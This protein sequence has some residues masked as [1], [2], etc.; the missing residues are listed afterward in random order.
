[1]AARPR[2]KTGGEKVLNHGGGLATRSISSESVKGTSLE[3]ETPGGRR[4]WEGPGLGRGRVEGHFTIAHIS[5]S[6]RPGPNHFR[7]H[8]P[9]APYHVILKWLPRGSIVHMNKVISAE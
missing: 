8:Y 1:M 4:D 5:F 7:H 6:S 2:V 9:Q 3:I